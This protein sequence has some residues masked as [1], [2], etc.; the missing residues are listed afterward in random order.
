M[1]GFVASLT[2]LL[3]KIAALVGSQRFLTTLIG[4]LMIAAL[5]QNAVAAML[6]LEAWELPDEAV[7]TA[8]LAEVIGVIVTFITAIVGVLQLMKNLQTSVIDDPPHLSATWKIRMSK[9]PASYQWGGEGRD[10]AR[11]AIAREGLD[12]LSG[13]PL[14]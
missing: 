9:L 3:E 10:P 8:Q 14:G 1:N 5:V 4:V 12:K 2:V 11:D 13:V 7:M 6:G